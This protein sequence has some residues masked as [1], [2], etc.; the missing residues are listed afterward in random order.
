MGAPLILSIDQGTSST[1]CLLID[2]AG[3]V[4]ARGSCP[5]DERHPAPGWVEQDAMA[6]WHS[7]RQAVRECLDGQDAGAVIGVAIS[8][9]RES[10]VMW[11]RRSGDPVSPV[12]S[13]QDQRTA[14][15]CDHIRAP[16]TLD[17][18]RRRS[19]LPLDP[20]FSA[21][22]AKWLLDDGDP[23]RARARAGDLCLGTID[24]WLLS[25]FG[26]GH[27]VEA[28]NASRTQLMDVRRVDWDDDLL[29]LFGVPRAAL[30]QIMPST[31]PFPA[32][33]GLDPLPDGVPVLSVLGDSHAALFAHGA[34]AP[35]PV[36]ATY[37]T[38]SSV[39]GLIDAPEDLDP[40]LCLTIGWMTDSAAFAAEGNIRSAGA[41][42]RW[43]AGVLGMSTDDLAERAA[44]ASA[45]GVHVVPGFSGLGAPWW[46]RGTTGIVTGLTLGSGPDA[47]ARAALESIPQQVADVVEAVDRS[48]GTVTVLYAD[49]GPTRNPVLMQLQA[50]LIGRPVAR[51]MTAELSALGAAHLAG[52]AAGVWDWQ[53]L[54]DLPRERQTVAPALA[55]DRRTTARNHWRAAVAQA[56]RGGTVGDPAPSH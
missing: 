27:M 22:K 5:L 7:V 32:A 35:G 38:G 39:M 51:S 26:G 1:K 19:G 46:D 45:D 49:G 23:S 40:G 56:R 30:P 34:F 47:L 33:S 44:G 55:D 24:S 12:L 3:A 6:V 29:A 17:F 15:A 10:L 48:I 42:L 54:R 2:H 36:K 53:A 13:W 4:V 37:G 50:D 11:D 25:R 9:Q 18:V 20:M 52:L 21:L 28:G 41:T 16:D 8:N 14:A 31:G 43:M